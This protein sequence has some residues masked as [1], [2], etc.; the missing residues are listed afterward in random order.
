ME[1]KRSSAV[2]VL[3]SLDA[4]LWNRVE[5]TAFDQGA[6]ASAVIGAAVSAH[7]NRMSTPSTVLQGSSISDGAYA[8]NLAEVDPEWDATGCC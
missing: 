7:I 4:D 1:I 3:V 8:V 6:S 2:D 5:A